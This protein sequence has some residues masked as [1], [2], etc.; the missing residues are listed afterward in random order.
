MTFLRK[1]W[2]AFQLA[3][4][5]GMLGDVLGDG[6][7]AE[8]IELDLDRTTIKCLDGPLEGM[9]LKATA[10]VRIGEA[11]NL[12]LTRV[13]GGYESLVYRI[14]FVNHRRMAIYV[15]RSGPR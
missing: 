2:R 5:K 3:L 14:G 9:R 13:D 11:W 15:D 8:A 1:C 6:S 10:G 4:L 12:A 7:L